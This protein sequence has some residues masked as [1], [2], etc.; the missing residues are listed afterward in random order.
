MDVKNSAPSSVTDDPQP[1]LLGGD[2][3]LSVVATLL[4]AGLGGGILQT[5]G[6]A[7]TADSVAPEERGDA[8]ASNGTF[9]AAT[10]LIAPLGVGALVLAMPIGVA[11]GIAGGV[12]LLPALVVTRSKQPVTMIAP[13]RTTR[14]GH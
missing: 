8:I 2:R 12:M 9:R 14:E 10:L 6:P 3:R 7:L 1:E 5:V 13:S 11:L 4:I